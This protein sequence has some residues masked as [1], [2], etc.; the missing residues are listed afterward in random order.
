MTRSSVFFR[1]VVTAGLL[2]LL[3][4][5]ACAGGEE[6]QRTGAAG[7]SGA[8][9][10]GS[11]PAG[12]TGNG[13][14]QAG[15]TGSGTGEAGIGGGEAG[16][17]GGGTGVAGTS[18]AAGTN[19]GVA[20]TSGGEAGTSGGAGVTGKAGTG[21]AAGV[22]GAAG[23]GGGAAGTGA[24]TGDLRHGKSSGCGMAPAAGDAVGKY[25]K[26]D[27]DV[28]GVDPAYLAAHKANVGGYTFTHRNYFVKLPTGYAP[29][30]AYALHF[31]GGGCGD[32][33]GTSGG[34][35]GFGVNGVAPGAIQVGL[36]YVYG[37]GQ[38]ACFQDSG[39]NTP[40]VPYFDAVM[41]ELDAHYCFDRGKV[42]IGGYSSGA[43]EAYTL[44]LARSNVIRGIAT[45]AGGLRKDRPPAAGKPFAAYLLTGAGDTTNPIDG[46]TG[47][48]LARDEILKT[49]GCM[50][51][52]SSNWPGM[53]GCVQYTACPAAFPVIWCTPGGGHTDGGAGWKPAISMG[54]G[55]LP[56][57]P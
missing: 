48:G 2:G 10:S 18:G 15:T 29:D 20:G 12:T 40:E 51:S 39:T 56:A 53:A 46:A 30:T 31:G 6:P 52:P 24:A 34:G 8:A 21:G 35:G 26:H 41:K 9:G 19:G 27:I 36:S 43:W 49:N 13:S 50:G 55:G 42:F 37:D 1:P 7:T 22:A 57:V 44:G 32:T 33:G 3:S 17:T 23:T 45:A 4:L 25:S 11:G 16:T 47:S 54:W 14:G 38:G 28:T 5:G